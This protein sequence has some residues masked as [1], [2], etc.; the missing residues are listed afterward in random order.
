MTAIP[1]TELPLLRRVIEALREIPGLMISK[2][3]EGITVEFFSARLTRHAVTKK[4]KV[5]RYQVLHVLFLNKFKVRAAIAPTCASKLYLLVVG[6][7][8]S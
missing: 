5:R 8:D 1:N 2:T 6:V 4:I 3:D 7:Q